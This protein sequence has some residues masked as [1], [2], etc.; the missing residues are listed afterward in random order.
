MERDSDPVPSIVSAIED[1]VAGG[2]AVGEAATAALRG[3]AYVE[4]K[5]WDAQPADSDIAR[6]LTSWRQE[7][8]GATASQQLRLSRMSLDRVVLHLGDGVEDPVRRMEA[9]Y[10]AWREG[11]D[12][13]V[14]RLLRDEVEQHVRPGIDW[15]ASLEPDWLVGGWLPSARITSLYAD[16]GTGKTHIGVQL[17]VALASGVETWIPGVNGPGIDLDGEPRRVL[18]LSWED[19]PRAMRRM[20]HHAGMAIGLPDVRAVVE[21]RLDFR[22]VGSLGALWGPV[23]GSRHTSTLSGF[24]PAGQW[25]V[26]QMPSYDLIILDPLAA[27]YAS[28]ENQRGLVRAFLAAMD[29][30]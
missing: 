1:A 17:G 11:G 8:E 20:A 21:D 5:R 3:T 25:L 23:A 12:Q 22:S 13:A 9:I 28:D 10:A 24:T 18:F 15:E 2:L 30:A 29:A 7:F 19:T 26:E 6:I 16:G 4:S 14:H 27:I